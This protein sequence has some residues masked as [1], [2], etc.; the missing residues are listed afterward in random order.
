[1]SSCDQQFP[2]SHRP[3]RTTE[4]NFRHSRVYTNISTTWCA[5]DSGSISAASSSGMSPVG[6][7]HRASTTIF[8]LSPPPPPD[9]PM[10]PICQHRLVA[11]PPGT[12]RSRRPQN[13]LDDDGVPHRETPYPFAELRDSPREFVLQG[14]RGFLVRK[15]VRQRQKMGPSRYSCRSLPQMPYH[16][17]SIFT[18]PAWW[19]LLRDVLDADVLAG[20]ET[21]CL[22]CGSFLSILQGH[23]HLLVA[24]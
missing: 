2:Y 5:T 9:S 4:N 14:H 16:A 24:K 11:G 21:C 22:H 7:T 1:M 13:K 19:F 6:C 3:L 8:S 23:G 20:V 18:A 12:C 10:K 15:Q 17:T